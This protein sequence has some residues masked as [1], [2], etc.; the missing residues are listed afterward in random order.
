MARKSNT[1]LM[2]D[3]VTEYLDG[4]M[5]RMFFD[6]DFN[7][8][9]IQYYPAMERQDSEMAECFVFYLAE[10][11]VDVSEHLSDEQ[12]RQLIQRQWDQ[13]NDA[14]DDGML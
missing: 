14:I 7:H 3:F 10:R 8:Y 4:D 13:F 2:F 11:G 1:Q 9:L 5:E 12:H 6:L